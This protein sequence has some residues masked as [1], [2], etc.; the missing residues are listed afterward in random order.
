MALSAGSR[1]GSF[2]ILST[3]GTGGMGVVYRA[4]DTK[5]RRD[6]A[7][8]ILPDVFAR[9]LFVCS[10]HTWTTTP[11][12]RRPSRVLFPPHHRGGC[13][14]CHSAVVGLNSEFC[15]LNY[16]V[17]S[18]PTAFELIALVGEEHVEAGE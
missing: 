5:L 12:T 17:S 10:G 9:D 7:L 2:E 6:V 15:I 4:R 8:K 14:D 11:Q 18:I 16:R 3:L 13:L 1:L